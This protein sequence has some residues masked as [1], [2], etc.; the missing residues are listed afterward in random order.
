MSEI[1]AFY[2]TVYFS[3]MVGDSVKEALT[4]CGKTSMFLSFTGGKHLTQLQQN[5]Y[6]GLDD[7]IPGRRFLLVARNP[8]IY[9]YS[10]LFEPIHGKR[11]L[12]T[13][14]RQLAKVQASLCIHAVSPEPSLFAHTRKGLRGSFIQTATSLTLLSGWACAFEGFQTAQR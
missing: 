3:I 12:I 9:K 11:V 6:R 4:S 10:A 8:H 7:G 5:T 2:G 14:F 13:Y 1:L